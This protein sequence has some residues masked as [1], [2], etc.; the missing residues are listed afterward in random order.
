[1]LSFY[2]K[3]GFNELSH[4]CFVFDLAKESDVVGLVHMVRNQESTLAGLIDIDS[5]DP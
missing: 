5:Y 4:P 3:V 1:L 2:S